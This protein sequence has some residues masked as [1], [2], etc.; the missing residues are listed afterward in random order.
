MIS[1]GEYLCAVE[2]YKSYPA[3]I[4]EGRMVILFNGSW[5]DREDFERFEK[6]PVIPDF[7]ANLNNCD[8]SKLYLYG[9]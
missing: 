8:K 5:I 1:V 2:L 9:T 4:I 6:M 7:K 3:K